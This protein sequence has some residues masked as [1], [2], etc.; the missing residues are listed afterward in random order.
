MEGLGSD[1]QIIVFNKIQEAPI[2]FHLSILSKQPFKLVLLS[3]T[4]PSILV[5]NL[6]SI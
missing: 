2:K 3:V 6:S 4:K 1:H 5:D